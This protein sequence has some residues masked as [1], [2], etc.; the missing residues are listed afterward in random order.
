MDEYIV[1]PMCC[2][3]LL[4]VIDIAPHAADTV[5]FNGSAAAADERMTR[6]QSLPQNAGSQGATDTGNK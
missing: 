4:W 3:E 6:L 1:A 5:D 2:V